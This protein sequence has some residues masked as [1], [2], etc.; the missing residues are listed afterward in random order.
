MG[1]SFPE[2]QV[3]ALMIGSILYGLNLVT[4]WLTL[5]RL[6]R[7]RGNWKR[8][9]DINFPMTAVVIVLFMAST[10]NLALQV[11]LVMRMLSQSRPEDFR[12][13]RSKIIVAQAILLILETIIADGVLVLD[14]LE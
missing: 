4:V 6:F 3:L 13:E 14:R 5:Q 11:A 10:T 2:G 1:H 8:G 12:V 7:E 9:W